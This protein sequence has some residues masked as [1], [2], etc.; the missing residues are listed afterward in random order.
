MAKKYDA[1]CGGW[2]ASSV[3]DGA[4]VVPEQRFPE[5]GTCCRLR[6]SEENAYEKICRYCDIWS[7][8]PDGDNLSVSHLF[9]CT[10]NGYGKRLKEK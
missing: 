1:L 6:M 9:E 3:P 8:L 2:K 10:L 4:C 7:S 5:L